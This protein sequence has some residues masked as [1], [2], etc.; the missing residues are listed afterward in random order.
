MVCWKS[1]IHINMPEYRAFFATYKKIMDELITPASIF[2]IYTTNAAFCGVPFEIEALW[3]T[4]AT[5]SCIKPA[6]WNRLELYS[7]EPDR[8]KLAGIGGKVDAELTC[9]DLLLAAELKIRKCPIYAVD[10]PGDADILIGMDIIGMG[11]FAVCNVDNKTTFSFAVPPFP[12][13]INLA[14]KAEAAN[15][16]NVGRK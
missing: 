4:G 9:V 1:L 7:L 8:T 11:D 13:R 6:L 2:P 3:D 12:D 16:N 10:F 14:E 15:K 5:A